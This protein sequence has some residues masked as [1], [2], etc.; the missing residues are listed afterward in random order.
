MSG[1]CFLQLRKFDI[2]E[3]DYFFSSLEIVR[4]IKSRITEYAKH[5]AHIKETK[6]MGLQNFA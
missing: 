5:A 2:P 4:M 1:F 3:L 6:R